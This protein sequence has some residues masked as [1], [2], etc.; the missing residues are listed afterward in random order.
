[1]KV[2][3]IN[4]DKFNLKNVKLYSGDLFKGLES[5]KFH[6]I[7]SNPPYIPTKEIEKLQIEV[8]DFEPMEAL[9]GGEDGLDYYRKII[10]RSKAYLEEDGLLIFE[11]GHN[12]GMDVEKIFLKEGFKKVEILKD[13]QGLDRVVFGIK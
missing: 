2:A 1:M 5:E 3:S 10:P 4:R 7:G 6:I 11:I 12:Q 13:L 8:R 9:D